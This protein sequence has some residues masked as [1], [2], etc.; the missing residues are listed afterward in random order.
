MASENKPCPQDDLDNLFTGYETSLM[1]AVRT[2]VS[3]KTATLSPE[4]KH[5]AYLGAAGELI[6]AAADI[7]AVNNPGVRVV[8]LG[9]LAERLRHLA[10]DLDGSNYD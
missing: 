10:C 6:D 7:A 5:R 1:E 3:V 8:Q 4:L 2:F 9:L